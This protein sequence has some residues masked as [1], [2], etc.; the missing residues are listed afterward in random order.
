[1][2]MIGRICPGV[3]IRRLR[4]FLFVSCLSAPLLVAAN[5]FPIAIAVI[6]PSPGGECTLADKQAGQL[7]AYVI[8]YFGINVGEMRFRVETGGGF[9]GQLLT[10]TY[11]SLNTIGNVTDGLGVF[12]LGCPPLERLVTLT[13]QTFGTSP[14]CSYLEVLPYP[15]DAEITAWDCDFNPMS[16]STPGTTWVNNNGSCGLVWCSTVATR[17]S[18]WGKVKA[19]YR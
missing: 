16:V 6:P 9:T 19:L 4:R 14:P 11:G 18:T 2:R 13:Y 17:P 15:G 8:L 10:E 12:N 5:A 3:W 1:M 7:T